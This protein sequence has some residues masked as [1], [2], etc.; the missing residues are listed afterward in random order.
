[1]M[2][3][4]MIMKPTAVTCIDCAQ[5]EGIAWAIDLFDE[6]GFGMCLDDGALYGTGKSSGGIDKAGQ[7]SEG[8]VATMELDTDAHIPKL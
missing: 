4:S 2:A 8:Q 5:D 7:D 1:M 6:F 3:F